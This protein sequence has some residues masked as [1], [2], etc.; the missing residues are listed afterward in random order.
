[1]VLR[2][3]QILKYSLHT[4]IAEIPIGDVDILRVSLPLPNAGMESAMRTCELT[5]C[6]VV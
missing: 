1:V 2:D 4:N 3:F 5:C 6:F